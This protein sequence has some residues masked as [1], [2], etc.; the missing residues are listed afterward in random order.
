MKKNLKTI[1]CLTSFFIIS[2]VT[3]AVS[4]GDFEDYVEPQ[5]FLSFSNE[6]GSVQLNS[7]IDLEVEYLNGEKGPSSHTINLQMP[8]DS[9]M[10][11]WDETGTMDG[12]GSFF[13]GLLRIMPDLFI[14]DNLAFSSGIQIDRTSE[15]LQRMASDEEINVWV[16]QLY[17]S[18]FFPVSFDFNIQAGKFASPFGTFY[19]RHRAKNNMLIGR[20]LMFDHNVPLRSDRAYMMTREFQMQ[21]GKGYS[22]FGQAGGEDKWWSGLS[23]ISAAP[24][25]S[26]VMVYGSYKILEYRVALVNSSLSNPQEPFEGNDNLSYV[27]RVSLR[28]VIGLRMG[29]SYALGAYMDKN[30]K[31]NNLLPSG[32]DENDFKQQTIGVD[33]EYS[34]GHLDIYGEFVWNSWKVPIMSSGMTEKLKNTTYYIGSKYTFI[35]GLYG[36]IRFS[37]INFGD[38]TSMMFGTTSWDYDVTR[39]EIGLGYHYNKNILIKTSYQFNNSDGPDPNDNLFGLQ[40][41]FSY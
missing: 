22:P 34:I 28:P 12:G 36:A 14:G 15:R 4:S 9:V 10:P 17:A 26:G 16:D 33:A 2:L 40:I 38:V 8:A 18:Y 23:T 32:K 11:W 1:F 35:P 3:H 31:D 39:T 25:N 30:L 20:P 7:A 6:S 37:S 5:S 41:S 19:E 29:A 13:N 27:G 21:R 24:Y